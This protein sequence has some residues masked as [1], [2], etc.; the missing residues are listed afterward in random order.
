MKIRI[1]LQKR[2]I[3]G[4]LCSLPLLTLRVRDKHGI[5]LD[6]AFRLDTGADTTTIPVAMARREGIPFQEGELSSVQGLAGLAQ[7]F[8]GRIHVRIAGRDYDWPCDFLQSP[9]VRGQGLAGREL[10]SVLGRAGFLNHFAFCLDGDSL[11]LTRLDPW[12]RR[13]QSLWRLLSNP[14]VRSFKPDEP[15]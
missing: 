12:R 11:T 14:F 8:R 15:I 9:A 1:Q 5:F 6:M 7:R 13:W 10:P 2:T 3:A 4:T